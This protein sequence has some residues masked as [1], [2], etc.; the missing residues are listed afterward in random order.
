MGVPKLQKPAGKKNDEDPIFLTLDPELEQRCPNVYAFLTQTRYDDG[1]FRTTATLLFFV[2]DA[3]IKVC[4]N[5]RENNRSLFRR[6]GSIWGALDAVEEAIGGGSADWK[7]KK[8][9]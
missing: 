2:E 3:A 9:Q 4:I 6:S 5:D 7:A 1:S 8:I